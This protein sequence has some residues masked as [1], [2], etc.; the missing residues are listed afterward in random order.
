LPSIASG[1]GVIAVSI[2]LHFIPA[3]CDNH[4]I[5]S[6]QA[7]LMHANGLYH[8]VLYV[9]N[10]ARSVAFYQ[11]LLGFI[12]IGQ[13]FGGKAQAFRGGD[14]RTHHELLLI[15]V[16][17]APGPSTG[18]RLG[19]YHLG[20]KVG[21]SMDDLRAAKSELDAAGVHID[22]MSDH[23]VTWSIYT[24]DPDGNELELY[25]DNPDVDWKTNPEAVMAPAK[26]LLL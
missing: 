2:L 18:R 5:S 8:A 17:D 9:R 15:E 13:A 7:E 25:A 1:A 23:T 21:D 22:G 4:N 19:L 16:G 26:R 24:R 3:P 12:P 11:D 10:L 20:I 14:H 6:H